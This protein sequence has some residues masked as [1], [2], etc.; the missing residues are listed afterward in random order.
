[1]KQF[2]RRK[3]VKNTGLTTGAV[4]GFPAIV[5]GQNLNSKI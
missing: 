2:T 4:L 3:F 5:S 1:M